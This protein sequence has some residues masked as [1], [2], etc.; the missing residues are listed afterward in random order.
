MST[1]DIDATAPL[2]REF[3][4]YLKG[5]EPPPLELDCAQLLESWR[6]TLLTRDSGP[7]PMVLVLVGR[8]TGHPRLSDGRTVRTS[9]LIWLDRSLKWARTWNRV[10]RLGKRANDESIIPP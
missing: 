9:Q 3:E 2:K 5:E 1:D 6:T 10:Y 7:L 4:T 8:V